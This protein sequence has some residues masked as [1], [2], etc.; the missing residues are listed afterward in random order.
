MA[1]TDLPA[2]AIR[3]PAGSTRRPM[4]R[5]VAAEFLGSLL[6]T[7]VVVGSGIAA[8]HLSPNDI[9]LQLAENA[10]ATGAGLYALI[11]MFAPISGAHFNP[12]VSL[13][14]ALLGQLSWRYAAAYFPAQVLG[15][16]TGA[17]LANVMFG[18]R[19]VSISITSRATLPHGISEVVATAGLLLVIFSLTR[20]GRGQYAPAAVGAYIGAAYFFTSSTSFAN[21][22]I[23]VGRI[24]SDTFA[25]IAP[26]SAPAY[27][28]AQL[29][30]TAVAV[31]TI[32]AI[33]PAAK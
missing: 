33:Y 5:A 15:C 7:A 17:V 13:A 14:A 3:P 23:T 20:T 8:Q 1:V 9:G 10:A 4:A 11:L 6:L 18:G 32:R 28:L 31:A 21:P 25:G 29:V 26:T 2:G 22:A 30:G 24:F 19:P 27:V 16:F 12:A